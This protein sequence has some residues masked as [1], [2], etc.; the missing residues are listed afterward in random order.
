LGIE[1]S[2]KDNFELY[3]ETASWLNTRHVEGGLSRSGIDCSGFVYVVYKNVYGI[4][5][6]R[7]SS[8]IYKKNC[9]RISKGRLK[10]GDLVFFNTSGSWFTINHVGIYLKDNKFVHT[11]T[12]KGV[13]VNSLEEE[14]Y[15]KTWVCGGRVK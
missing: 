14:Y 12:S 11:S 13:I 4:R 3:K 10:G 15:R 1:E 8:S 5:L 7:S 6:E 2:H 9:R